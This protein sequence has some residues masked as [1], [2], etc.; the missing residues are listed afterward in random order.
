M[1][2]ISTFFRHCDLDVLITAT[3][4][5]ISMLN[6]MA[7][8]QYEAMPS[9]SAQRTSKAALLRGPMGQIRCYFKV[10]SCRMPFRS[11][12]RAAD[13]NSSDDVVHINAR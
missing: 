9:I 13:G 3:S 5:L 4:L 6:I 10:N 1:P 7:L 2:R 12:R 8:S 11:W